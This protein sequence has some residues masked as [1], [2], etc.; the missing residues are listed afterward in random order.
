MKFVRGVDPKVAIGI[1]LHKDP[2]NGQKFLVRFRLRESHPMYYPLQEMERNGESVIAIA[3]S[4][5]K[6]HSYIFPTKSV[7]CMIEG[8]PE[9]FLALIDKEGLWEITTG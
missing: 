4:D 3:L 8:L 2:A 7:R 9:V 6:Y 5:V 1:G